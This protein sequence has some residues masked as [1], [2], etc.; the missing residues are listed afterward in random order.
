MK[1]LLSIKEFAFERVIYKCRK[2]QTSDQEAT[3][4]SNAQAP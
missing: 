2:S 1:E 4:S 3:G